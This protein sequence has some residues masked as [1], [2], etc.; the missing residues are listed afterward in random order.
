MRWEEVCDHP[1]LQDVPFK[2]ESNEK[3][4]I[5]MNAVKVIHSLY[6]GEIECALRSLLN[7]GRALPE[8]AIK[9][10]KGT[11]V[12]DVAWAT[13]E[14]L[15][16]RSGMRWSALAPP[17]VALRSVLTAIRMMRWKNNGCSILKGVPRRYGYAWMGI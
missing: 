15:L 5:I 12:A 14:T 11:K 6:Q 2:I 16:K 9:T 7:G 3:G 4:E 10:R 13:S 8:C 17:K 1:D